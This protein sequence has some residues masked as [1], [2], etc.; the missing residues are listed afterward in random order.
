MEVSF[1]HIIGNKL[2]GDQGEI[3]SI[4]AEISP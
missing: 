1:F 2:D 3:V 4:G